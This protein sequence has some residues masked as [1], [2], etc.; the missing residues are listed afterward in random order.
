MS[1]TVHAGQE[2]RKESVSQSSLRLI[3]AVVIW[4]LVWGW[5]SHFQH[6]LLSKLLGWSLFMWTTL[7]SSWQGS[8][9]V[10]EWAK[11]AKEE[12]TMP[13]II[14]PWKAYAVTSAVFPWP[15]NY[16]W[17]NWYEEIS[18]NTQ[19]QVYFGNTLETVHHT[20]CICTNIKP[21][22]HLNYLT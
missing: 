15:F 16:P 7:V 2:F 1:L 11:E 18:M 13:L 10:P 12:T 22:K 5:Q 8:W 19:R 4:R 14:C 17:F 20:N 21:G 3:S 6:V 9:L